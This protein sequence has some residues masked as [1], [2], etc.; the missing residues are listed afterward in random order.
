MRL[1]DIVSAFALLV[2]AAGAAPAAEDLRLVFIA[3]Q[4]PDQLVDN[5]EPVVEYLEQRLGVGVKAFVATDYAAVV[6]ALRGGTADAGFMGPLQYVLAH[7]E[8]GAYPILGEVYSGSPT[9]VSRIFVRKDSGIESV[10]QLKDRSIA[11]VDPLSSSGYMYPLDVFKQQ[12]LIGHRDDADAFFGRIYFAGGD[13]QAIRA[14]YNGF[15]DAAGIGQYSFTL[16]RPGERDQ[17]VA[18]GESRPIPSHCVVVRQGADPALVA[19]L[20]E[21]LLALNEGPNR[22]LLEQLYNVDGYI[23]VDH[24]TYSGVAE[25]AKEYGFVRE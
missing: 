6:E 1:R 15:V 8:A 11:F 22:N 19:G 12:G 23:E 2:A 4:N 25:L 21:A 14:V 3:Y 7:Q 17:M 10:E 13:E 24:S 5:V 16:L 9:Y 18:I 20:R